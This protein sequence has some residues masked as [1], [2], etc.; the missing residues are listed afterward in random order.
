MF[1]QQSGHDP[2]VSYR[3]GLESLSPE[4]VQGAYAAHFG[5]L[6]DFDADPEQLIEAILHH[7]AKKMELGLLAE[8]SQRT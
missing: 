2:L 3:E 4:Q 1:A 6:P 8:I 7:A 5:V